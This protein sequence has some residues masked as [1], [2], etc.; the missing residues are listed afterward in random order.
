MLVCDCKIDIQVLI[1]FPSTR[2][3]P[4]GLC[5]FLGFTIPLCSKGVS[6]GCT[7]AH[8]VLE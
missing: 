8:A 1:F 5:L 3:V 7:D 4:V 2:R 6:L